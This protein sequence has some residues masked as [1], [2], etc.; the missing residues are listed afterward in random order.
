MEQD[1]HSPQPYDYRQYDRIW[2]RVAPGLEPY[3][4][5]AAPQ[6]AA[7]PAMAELPNSTPSTPESQLPGAEQNPCC[8]GTAA[9]DM[10]DVLTG[11]IEESLTDRQYFLAAA[12]QGPAWARQRLR[13]MAA[14]EAAHARR[15]MAVHYLI[16]G[17]CY[18]PALSRDRICIGQW[19][20]AL[21]ERYHLEACNGLNY[22]RAADGTTDPC[23]SRLLNELSAEE[24]RHADILMQM[25]ERSL[26]G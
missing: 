11:F 5:P 22:A 18:R 16:T 7:V 4:A 1:L 23:L 19:C 2:Q 17:S 25:L 9:A 26:Q 21:R 8:M 13:D 24:Y 12:R 15:L 6:T 14:D 20:P 10:L 3:P